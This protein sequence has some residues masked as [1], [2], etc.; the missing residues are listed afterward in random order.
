[1]FRL[2]QQSTNYSYSERLSIPE[3]ASRVLHFV[4]LMLCFIFLRVWY[5][6]VIQYEEKVAE[7]R[8]SQL[9]TSIERAERGTI[10]DRFNIPLAIN[11]VQYNA[12]LCY[13][14][15]R[16]MRAVAWHKDSEG[17]KKRSYPRR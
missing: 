13:A 15:V 14:P 4:F 5:L 2:R 9:R 6:T 12:A 11:Q 1:M 16:E 3:K 7:S 10:R 17:N 8:K